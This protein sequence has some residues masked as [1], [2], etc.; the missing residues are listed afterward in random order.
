MRDVPFGEGKTRVRIYRD[1][2]EL[3]KD[4]R[5]AIRDNP[6]SPNFV[7]RDV[8]FG[9]KSFGECLDDALRPHNELANQVKRVQK[10]FSDLT[11]S[12][13]KSR[14]K[15]SVVGRPVV[16]RAIAGHPLSMARRETV[17]DTTAPLSIVVDLGS[18]EAIGAKE[19]DSLGVYTCA[20]V[21]LL[22]ERRPVNLYLATFMQPDFTKYDAVG[23]VVPINTRPLDIPRVAYLM[24][25]DGFTRGVGHNVCRYLA[26]V[27]NSVNIYWP[28][29]EGMYAT[30]DYTRQFMDKNFGEGTLYLGPKFIKDPNLKAFRKDPEKWVRSL[31]DRYK[32]IR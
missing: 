26:E 3:V 30:K 6:T 9:N 29:R 18:S 5:G 14:R 25:S 19:L 27:P 16:P 2:S 28:Y 17:P 13:Y 31:V 15:Y 1:L 11:I 8:F 22:S 12:A 20:A 7:R 4:C 24:S 21:K 10:L 23:A 32:N